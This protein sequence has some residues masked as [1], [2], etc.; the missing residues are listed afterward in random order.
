MSALVWLHEDALRQDHPV[1]DL[2]GKDAT[3]CFIWDEG[4]LQQMDYGFHRCLFI[5]ESLCQ[6]SLT[7]YRG[8]LAQTL[9]ALMAEQGADTLF[10]PETPNP[11]LQAVA[12]QIEQQHTL[13]VVPDVP[14][15]HL[16]HKPDLKRFFRYW[17]KAKKQALQPN[18]GL[19]QQDA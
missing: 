15:V 6:L 16:K 11:Q 18:G 17:N 7:V 13:V 3:T 5:Y 14:F 10:M 19:S 2:A 12:R 8:S 9:L 4:Y 1:Y